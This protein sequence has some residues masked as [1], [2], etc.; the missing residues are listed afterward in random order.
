MADGVKKQSR[1]G[2]TDR[3]KASETGASRTAKPAATK[4]ATTPRRTSSA[5]APARVLM[6]LQE[7]EAS[8]ILP[9]SLAPA[10]PSTR[11]DLEE[12][13]RQL[14]QRLRAL[15]G[16]LMLDFMKLQSASVRQRFVKHR[17]DLQHAVDVMEQK[18]LEDIADKLEANDEALKAGINNL[19]RESEK[20]EDV[21]RV[22]GA[23]AALVEIVG[24]IVGMAA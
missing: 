1:A 2:G 23:I 4:R 20:L 15:Y 9:A 24:Q 11:E 17:A 22:L 10:A 14:R 21:V 5:R 13:K 18:E 6:D 16:P 3:G 19:K 12:F 8:F 7:F